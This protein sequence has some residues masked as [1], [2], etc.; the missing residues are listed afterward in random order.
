MSTTTADET[1]FKG[2]CFC[3]ALTYTVKGKPILSAYCHCTLCQRLAASPCVATIHFPA[4]AFNWTHAQPHEAAFDKYS[5]RFR[6]KS[7]GACT[8]SYN[9]IASKYSIWGAQLE[10]DENGK[11]RNWDLIKP[12]AHMFYETRMMDYNDDLPKWDGYEGKSRRLS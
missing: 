12:T 11:I 4:T 8:T 1:V 5:N 9:A 2:S 10:R 6:C 7:C 3:G